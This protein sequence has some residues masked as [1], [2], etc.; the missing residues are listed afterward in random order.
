MTLNFIGIDPDTG[1]SGSPT[2]WVEE[3]TADLIF[4]GITAED[5]LV[6]LIS[7]QGWAPGHD[8]RH[9]RSRDP[10]S[11]PG[12]VGADHQEGVR[13]RRTCPASRSF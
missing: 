7:S 10:G 4:L 8:S 3:E 2:V 13:C 12:T 6:A 1:K 5:E 9:P 11:Y